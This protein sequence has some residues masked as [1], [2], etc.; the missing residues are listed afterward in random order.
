MNSNLVSIIITTFNRSTYL[1]E[2]LNSIVNQSYPLIEILVIDDGSKPDIA[3]INK[4]ITASFSKC[5]YYYKA[6]TGQPDSR[7][8]GISR[9]K[10]AFVGFCDDDDFWVINKLEKQLAVFNEN[11]DVYVITGD[12]E[13]VAVT[14]QK[15]GRIKCHRGHNQGYVFASFLEKNRT[16]SIT[17][18]LR[19]EVFDKTGF[20]NPSYTIAEDWEFWRRVSYCFEFYSINE[21]LAYVR[22]HPENMSKTRTGKPFDSYELYRKLTK[23]LLKWGKNRFEPSDYNLIYKIEWQ[24]YRKLMANHYPGV[25]K[26]IGFIKSV[27]NNNII[28]GVHLFYLIIKYQ[29]LKPINKQLN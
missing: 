16:A 15:T 20:F 2:T 1:K 12:I 14:G 27:F 10:G 18:L 13:Y 9:S 25:L 26:K 17:P 4:E 21:V 28:E 29:F 23:S 6:N 24:R 3:K 5:S 8:Y 11:P 22:L 7:N 19:R